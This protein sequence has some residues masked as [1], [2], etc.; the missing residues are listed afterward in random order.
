M[1]CDRDFVFLR[2]LVLFDLMYFFKK[3]IYLYIFENTGEQLGN[4]FSQERLGS[5]SA[6][7]LGPAH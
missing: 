5:W 1:L 6:Y 2:E 4:L 3:N 7:L